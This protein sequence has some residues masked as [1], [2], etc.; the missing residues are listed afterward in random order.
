MVKQMQNSWGQ[1]NFNGN[2]EWLKTQLSGDWLVVFV[3]AISHGKVDAEGLG[4]H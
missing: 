1:I 2:G 3:I 4:S